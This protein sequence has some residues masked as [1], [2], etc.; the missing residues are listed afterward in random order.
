MTATYLPAAPQSNRWWLFIVT[1]VCWIAIA[2]VVLRFNVRTV[3]AVAVL[4]GVVILAAAAVE[5]I[6]A[7]MAPGWKWLHATLAALFLVTGIVALAHPGNTFFWLSAF[8]G[9]Y[10]L[11]KGA[12][13]ITLAFLTKKE[14]EAWWLLLIVGII[15]L[16]FGFWAA[17]RFERSAYL[18]VVY[19]AVIALTHGITDFAAAFRLR[20]LTH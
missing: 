13:D 10:L 9:W 5:A 20:N 14:N 18:L 3:G 11:F 2:W 17:G 8:I 6:H 4:A 15:E 1:G 19:V 12:A 16:G 7:F